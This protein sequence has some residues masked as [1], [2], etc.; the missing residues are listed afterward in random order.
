[1]VALAGLSERI[2]VEIMKIKE[3]QSSNH[4]AQTFALLLDIILFS[5]QVVA[6]PV[7]L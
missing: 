7:K 6:C 4:V 2:L 3:V 1:M 5:W